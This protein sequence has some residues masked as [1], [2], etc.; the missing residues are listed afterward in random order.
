MTVWLEQ[1]P[2][3][4]LRGT[5][6]YRPAL[7]IRLLD[8]RTHAGFWSAAWG[9]L[10]YSFVSDGAP[11]ESISVYEIVRKVPAYGEVP[12]SW[13]PETKRQAR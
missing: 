8:A 11:A 3:T 9:L 12:L 5:Y 13:Y 10:P 2:A 7:P 4:I 1:E 6:E